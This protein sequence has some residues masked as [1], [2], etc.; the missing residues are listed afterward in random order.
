M[1]K[2]VIGDLDAKLRRAGIPIHGVSFNGRIDFEESATK[3][4][5]QQARDI[6]DNYIQDDEDADKERVK[7]GKRAEAVA[8]LAAFDTANAKEQN[9]IIKR[10]LK[11][12][13][14]ILKSI[15]DKE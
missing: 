10:M 15:H 3:E 8:D 13:I 7:D 1:K 4:Q 6:V 12:Q 11:R 14:D 5:K 2:I 9:N